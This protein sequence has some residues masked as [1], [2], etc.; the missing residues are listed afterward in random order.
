[1]IISKFRHRFIPILFVVFPLLFACEQSTDSKPKRSKSA[2]LVEVHNARIEAVRTRLKTS[3]SLRAETQVKVFNEISARVLEL[4]FYPGDQVTSGQQ[5]ARLDDSLIRAELDKAT[6]LRKLARSDYD[7]LKKLKPNQL[8]SAEEIASAKTELDVALA[9]EKLQ[10]TRLAQTVIRAPFDGVITERLV[11]PGDVVSLHSHMLTVIDPG[12]LHLVVQL[13]EQWMPF[14]STGDHVSISID[15]LGNAVH[16]GSIKRIYPGIDEFT[17]KGT[18]EIGFDPQPFGTQPG[19]LARVELFTHSVDQ[20]VIPANSLHHDSSG[21]YVY[22]LDSNDKTNKV[23]V[24]KGQQYG[25]L[26]AIQ[27]GLDV[28]SRVVVK[29]F[30]GL[31]NGKKVKVV[32]G[33]ASPARDE[34]ANP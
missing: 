27:S 1:M 23:H 8:A 21:A 22:T 13:A 3:G 16:D 4:P 19:Q 12:S 5:I 18:I 32:D 17:R 14:V 9:E 28:N 24:N 20:L 15:A 29:G 7:R 6:A 25:N 2:H 30:I 26:L 31:R 10:K 33:S 11:E 34:A